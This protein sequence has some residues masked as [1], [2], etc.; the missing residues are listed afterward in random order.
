MNRETNSTAEPYNFSPV[1]FS[2]FTTGYELSE[3]YQKH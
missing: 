3:W 2:L 1:D